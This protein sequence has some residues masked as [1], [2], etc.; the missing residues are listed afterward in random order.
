MS[1]PDMHIVPMIE[2]V[3][4]QLD[5]LFADINE[6]ESRLTPCLRP[7]LE[8][9]GTTPMNGSV[10]NTPMLEQVDTLLAKA[11]IARYRINSILSRVAL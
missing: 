1:A 7:E 11:S 8:S 5:G 4:D 2:N 6:L 3:R 10:P 9:P